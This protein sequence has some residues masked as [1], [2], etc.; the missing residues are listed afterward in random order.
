MTRTVTTGPIRRESLWTVAALQNDLAPIHWDDD[1][2]R[3]AGA[4][5]RPLAQGTIVVELLVRAA[6][7]LAP[8]LADVAGV[9]VRYRRPVHAGDRLTITATPPETSGHGGADWSLVATNDDGTV[10]VEAT[11]T[12]RAG[13]PDGSSRR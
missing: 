13:A 6:A 1:A 2:V 5:E 10:V 12:P 7:Q 4:G 9:Q 11:L 3:A 8:E